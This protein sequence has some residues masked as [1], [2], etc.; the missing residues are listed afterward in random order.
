MYT[1]F[2]DDIEIAT[3]SLQ[4][5]SRL[6]EGKIVVVEN[7]QKNDENVTDAKVTMNVIQ[8]VANSINPMIRLTVETPCNS[9]NEKLP[10]LDVMVNVNDKEHDRIDFEFFEKPTK[11]PR[12]VLADSALSFSQKRTILTQEGLRRLRNTKIELG[13][14]VQKKHL[15][16]FMLK[17]KKSGYGQKFRTEILDSCLKAYEKMIE[18]DRKGIKPLYRSRDWNSEEREI[19]KS[20]KKLTWWNNEK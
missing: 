1:R 16:H 3:E 9:E 5:G 8:Q 2:K 4:K 6:K 15:N 13:A 14:V 10:V 18:D 7:E 20:K 12:V 19:A 17:L 11:N